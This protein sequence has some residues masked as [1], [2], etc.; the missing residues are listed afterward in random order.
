MKLFI[1]GILFF[2]IYLSAN[3]QPIL[4]LYPEELEFT[5]I[6][7]RLEN[8]YFINIGDAPLTI[9]SISYNND[10]YFVRFD[11]NWRYP[12]TIQPGDTMRMD[13]ILAGYINYIY[14]ETTDT[15]FVYNDGLNPVEFLKVKID[16]YEDNYYSGTLQGNIASD[17]LPVADAKVYFLYGGN[18]VIAQ[19]TSDINGN[20]SAEL[21]VGNYS[22]A[23]GNDSFYIS[24]YD[25]QFDPLSAT[26][27]FIDTNA[28]T[29][30][31][32][33]LVKKISTQNSVSGTIFDSTS[34]YPLKKGIIIVRSGTHTPS[35]MK[36]IKT[37]SPAVMDAYTAFT[38]A[39][40][41]YSVNAIIDPD[42]YYVQAFSDYFVPTYYDSLGNYPSFWQN[43]DS[44]FIN[45]E[46]NNFDIY[47]PR[48]SSLGGGI[49]SGVVQV[50]GKSDS[51]LTDVV[52][53]AQ[54][55]ENNLITYAFSQIDGNFK[56]NFL[57]YGSYYLVGQRIGFEDA[58]SDKIIIDS[59]T[60]SVG[61]VVLL[62]S[63]PNSVK[64]SLII[65]DQIQLYQNYPN[66]FNPTTTIEFLIPSSA[67]VSLSIT[68]ILGQTVSILH[69]GYLSSGHY[70]M[71]FDGSKLSSGIYFV[72]LT[73]GN[74]LFVRKIMLLK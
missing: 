43:A 45:S 73:A 16:Y 6:F 61:D 39:N 53:Y 68:N 4:Q 55:V 25:Q 32:L 64:Y 5:D 36:H 13:C 14:E 7:H 70:K 35:K 29:N 1:T 51:A 31:N 65:P 52:I 69:S 72:S 15:L 47:M 8:A 59:L 62:F 11:R 38:D 41:N 34:V 40:G 9:D 63:S 50:A 30:V 54:S 20:Y 56:E 71:Q 58:V 23:A 66:P 2:L 24:F 42:Y 27:V 44:I 10:I 21:P 57:P 46:L 67:D 19:T 22:I 12:F 49:I 28:V 60:T 33:N 74:T 48:D 26:Q 18:F 37:N 17:G 3:A